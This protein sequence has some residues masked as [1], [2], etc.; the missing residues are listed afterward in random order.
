MARGRLNRNHKD[1]NGGLDRSS[2][3]WHGKLSLATTLSAINA[4]HTEIT[5]THRELNPHT[6]THP[7]T[8]RAG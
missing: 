3:N 8:K 5:V 4:I 2:S 6:V 7:S 1:S